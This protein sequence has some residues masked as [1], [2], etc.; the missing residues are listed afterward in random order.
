MYN[1]A[2]ARLV[3]SD[4]LLDLIKE[5]DSAFNAE[6]FKR[7]IEAYAKGYRDGYDESFEG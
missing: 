5:A 1:G 3:E 4:E 6:L 2:L 7:K